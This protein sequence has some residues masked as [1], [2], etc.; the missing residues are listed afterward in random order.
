M[1]QQ[2]SPTVEKEDFKQPFAAMYKM[3][4]VSPSKEVLISEKNN[5]RFVEV[6]QYSFVEKSSFLLACAPGKDK[7]MED[8]TGSLQQGVIKGSLADSFLPRF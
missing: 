5:V 3:W 6:G 2:L 8:I 7:D 1:S 4:W